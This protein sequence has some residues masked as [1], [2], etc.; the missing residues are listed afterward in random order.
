MS[1]ILGTAFSVGNGLSSGSESNTDLLIS[2]FRRTKQPQIDALNK[3]RTDLETRQTFLNGFRSRLED[4][5]SKFSVF[6]ETGTA[7][8]RFFAN[9]TTSSD[10]SVL[11]TS[12]DTTALA[13]T[14]SLKVNRLAT[15][16]VLVSDRKSKDAVSSLAGTSQNFEI[17]GISYSVSIDENDTNEQ[18]FTKIASA[19]NGNTAS[20]V[21]ASVV[22]DT[23][24][25]VRLSFTTKDSGT[26]ANITFVDSD[27]LNDLGITTA[28]LNPNTDARQ[29][30]NATNAGFQRASKSDLDAS[31]TLDGIEVTRS[32]NTIADLITGVT[33]TLQ[34]A[35]GITDNPISLTT[36]KDSESVAKNVIQPLLDSFN[37]TLRYLN[38]NSTQ[39]RADTALQ[40]FRSRL[41]G[42]I[43][44]SV[45]SAGENNPKYLTELGITIAADG[46]L[47]ISDRKKLEDLLADNPQ[48]VADLFTGNDGVATKLERVLNGFLG[49]TG[50]INAR[51]TDLRSQIVSVGTRTKDVQQRID[52]QAENLRKEYE[53]LQRNFLK[54]QSQFSALSAFATNNT[55]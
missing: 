19:I 39:L 7:N 3:R 28:A 17:Q 9:K 2:A 4:L 41:R 10:I 43:S 8:T 46:T 49:D 36:T 37:D 13:G 38:N 25:T 44:E 31:L 6:K 11:T 20:K 42:V 23:S 50:L 26:D 34:K 54:A 24:S 12:S 29:V 32:T 21:R 40:G 47:S 16:D 45:S 27:V 48:K 55:I 35:Q 14:Y 22:R 30:L 1:D 53:N 5:Q 15:N 18:T 52:A 51:T 33:L